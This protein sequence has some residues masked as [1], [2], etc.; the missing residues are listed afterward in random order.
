V[1]ADD[2]YIENSAVDILYG[3]D[4]HT[5]TLASL[6]IAAS[7][8]GSIGL[9]NFTGSYSEY[10]DKVLRIS[11][12]SVLIGYGLG[13]GSPRLRLDTG[14]NSAAIMVQ[15]TGAN[16]DRTLPAFQWKGN[17][18]SNTLEVRKG[19]VGV[20]IYPGDT[21]QVAIHV[22]YTTN[23]AGDVNLRVGSGITLLGFGQSGGTAEISSDVTSITKTDGS[24]TVSGA[25][26]VP[27]LNNFG[28]TC[29]W[30]S[31]GALGATSIFIGASAKL[32]FSQD[33]RPKTV[34]SPVQLSPGAALN[35]PF[36]VATPDFKTVGCTLSDVKVNVGFDHEYEVA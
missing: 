17:H 22:G 27:T 36:G 29:Y 6:N 18:A 19:Q 10:R 4:Q 20:G 12:A 15:A 9:P 21:G 3:L 34:S 30:N 7:F 14:T 11:A 23:I 16:S 25:A 1:N 33:M 24:L 32:D 5:V 31:T 28:G 35:D 13:T 2:V 8:T 26:A